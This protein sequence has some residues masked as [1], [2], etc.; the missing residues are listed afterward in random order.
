MAPQKSQRTK[1][2]KRVRV[3]IT[4]NIE[5]IPVRRDSRAISW[6]SFYMNYH[7][8]TERLAADYESRMI[9]MAW[10]FLFGEWNCP[11]IRY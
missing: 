7:E 8:E 6:G 1:S 10:R 11:K 5:V 2:Q 4:N 9:M 3:K